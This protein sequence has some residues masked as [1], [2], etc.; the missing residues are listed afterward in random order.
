MC[1]YIYICIYTYTDNRTLQHSGARD[2]RVAARRDAAAAESLDRHRLNGYLVF[3][4]N[5]PSRTSQLKHVVKLLARKKPG[6][7]WAKYP[8]SRC[9][10]EWAAGLGPGP[11]IDVVAHEDH[12]LAGGITTIIVRI[13]II[14]RRRKRRK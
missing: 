7:R 4:G 14:R 9:R 8:F 2:S 11:G 10:L 5:I 3:Q 6:T 12:N 13:T 1:I